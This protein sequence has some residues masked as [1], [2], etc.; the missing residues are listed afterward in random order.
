MAESSK[1][2][3]AGLKDVNNNGKVQSDAK[4]TDDIKFHLNNDSDSSDDSEEQ[5]IYRNGLVN[6][7][8]EVEKTSKKHQ[9]V[10]GNQIVLH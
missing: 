5:N 1:S 4:Q 10:T 3:T 9:P 7:G 2:S 6:T 8:E